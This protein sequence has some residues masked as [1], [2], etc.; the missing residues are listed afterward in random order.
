MP[1]ETQAQPVL[2][3]LSESS[4][5]PGDRAAAA[6]AVPPAAAPAPAKKAG[7]RPFAILGAVVAVGALALAGFMYLNA[8]RENTDDAQVT[9]DLV[10]LGARVAGQVVSVLIHENQLVKAGDVIARIDDADY[11]ARVKQAEA[12]LES[13]RAQAEQA[14]AQVDIVTATSTGNLSSAKAAYSGSSVGVASAAAQVA[15]ARAQIVR[16]EA[17][18]RKAETDL[19]RAKELRAANAVPQE[20]VDNA[21]AAFDAAQAALALSRAQLTAAEEGRHAAVAR[22]S[23]AAGRVAQ[24]API[25][26]QIAA[27]RANADLA[28]ARTRSAE[29]ALELA[30]LQLS[31]TKIVAPSDGIAS[32]LS[33]HEGQLVGVGQP[34]VELVPT[35]TYV[36]AN[37]KET[38]LG[39]MHPGERAELKIDAYP[40]RSFEGKVE[41][42][43]GG[44]GSSFSLLPA[45]NAS[46]NFVK[47]VQRVPVRI[48]W[49]DPPADVVLR[50]GLS[51]DATVFVGK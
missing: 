6:P 26:A 13:T 51:V 9:A 46:G 16:S 48:A 12:E 45:D 44:T 42:I 50:A 18:A 39:K 5:A 20:R 4:P 30:K 21:Q 40:H 19:N 43:S 36:I 1:A 25:N 33:V 11:V 3:D 22:V 41:S 2:A 35:S 15:A 49:V 38:Q 23:E 14:K 10:P 28:D 37:F 31:Y 27:A 17:D 8:G 32:K 24:S 34:I 7:R 29:S 47:V